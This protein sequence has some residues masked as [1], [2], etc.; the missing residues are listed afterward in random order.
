MSKYRTTRIFALQAANHDYSFGPKEKMTRFQKIVR[1]ILIAPAVVLFLMPSFRLGIQQHKAPAFTVPDKVKLGT[2]FTVPVDASLQSIQVEGQAL[3]QI[4]AH[5][6]TLLAAARSMPFL[7][8][9]LIYKG[10]AKHLSLK[11]LLP[12]FEHPKFDVYSKR[13]VVEAAAAA[14]ATDP[15]DVFVKPDASGLN[16][17]DGVAQVSCWST[18]KTELLP[19]KPSR[20]PHHLPIRFATLTAAGSGEVVKIDSNPIGK[21]L[22][23]YHG[24]GLY[25]RYFELKEAHVKKGD[26]IEAGQDIGMISVGTWRHPIK[27]KWDIHLGATDI[28]LPSFLALSAEL[29]DSK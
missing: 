21:N 2:V 8:L 29:C 26:R 7:D 3:P 4:K 11:S 15:D 14:E 22:T 20:K 24:G 5:S 16:R 23:V 27:G 6:P 18:P 19:E 13:I 12:N 17:A 28:N 10:P 1:A 25:T 9:V